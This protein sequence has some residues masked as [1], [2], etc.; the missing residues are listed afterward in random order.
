MQ[1]G[2]LSPFLSFCFKDVLVKDSGVLRHVV[3]INGANVKNMETFVAKKLSQCNLKSCN[4]TK[5]YVRI[6]VR[7]QRQTKKDAPPLQ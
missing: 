3:G 5:I 7:A 6:H 2:T 4:Y 1:F